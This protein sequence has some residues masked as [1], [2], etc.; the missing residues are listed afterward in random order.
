V[1][2]T[3]ANRALISSKPSGVTPA[4][5]G[6][7]ITVPQYA[8]D[9]YG[10]ITSAVN[11]PI[12]FPPL[13]IKTAKIRV[14]RSS[15]LSNFDFHHTSEQT[16][17]IDSNFTSP[18]PGTDVAVWQFRHRVPTADFA[19]NSGRLTYNN[20][21]PASFL[22]SACISYNDDSVEDEN[23]ESIN[24]RFYILKNGI[25]NVGTVGMT[26]ITTCKG[27]NV[28]QNAFVTLEQGEF[29][30]C[31]NRTFQGRTVTRLRQIQLS[32]FQVA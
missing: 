17:L 31:W 24:R 32:C 1:V 14:M 10:R 22:C 20:A 4:T 13:F 30:S 8:V 5:Y 7:S 11:V 19:N 26:Q 6:D 18:E 12:N 15:L 16:E 27:Y 23:C 29:I 25:P 28:I 9:V 3:H 2:Y 21:T